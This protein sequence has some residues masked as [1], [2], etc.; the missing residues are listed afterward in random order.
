MALNGYLAAILADLYA[1]NSGKK[2][3]QHKGLADLWRIL[4]RMLE[5][6]DHSICRSEKHIEDRL[7]DGHQCSHL[8][9]SVAAP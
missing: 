9:R 1:E 5:G 7:G 3:L 2:S 4:W 8:Y 6:T